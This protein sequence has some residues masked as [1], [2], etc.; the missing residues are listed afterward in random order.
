MTCCGREWNIN[1][2][3]KHQKKCGQPGSVRV[4]N[5]DKGEATFVSV[6]EFVKNKCRMP[7]WRQDFKESVEKGKAF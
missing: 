3:R 6:D 7:K 4:F 2:F 1:D 5:Y